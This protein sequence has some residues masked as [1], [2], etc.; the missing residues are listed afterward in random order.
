MDARGFREEL[1]KLMV[2]HAADSYKET[3]RVAALI[4]DKAQKV[5]A[6]AGVFLAAGLGFL[7]A[8]NLKADSPFGGFLTLVLLMVTIL[9]LMVTVV[10]CLSVLWVREQAAPIRMPLL[11]QMVDQIVAMPDDDITNELQDTARSQIALWWTD[12]LVRQEAV[13]LK[14]AR[15]VRTAQM[16]L[17]SAIV[18][19][20]L[21]ILLVLAQT[22][23]GRVISMF[24]G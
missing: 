9:T 19:I 8:E 20:A 5:A 6:V 11:R 7:K 23:G 18:A 13:N 2:T 16:L 10:V 3:V 15:G 12:I 22:L 14:K 1:L 21:T 24:A 4:E 17:T